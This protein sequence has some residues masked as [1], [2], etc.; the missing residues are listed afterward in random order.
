M[1]K[2]TAKPKSYHFSIGNSSTG[3]IGLCGRVRAKSKEE[4]AKIFRAALGE[5]SKIVANWDENVPD[6]AVEYLRAYFNPDKITEKDI[7]EVDDE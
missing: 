3:Q 4:A 1:T 6:G 5:E 7:D 2:K